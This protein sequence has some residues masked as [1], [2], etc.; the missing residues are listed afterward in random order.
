MAVKHSTGSDGTFSA[1]GATAWDA[2][3]TVDDNTLVAA[4]LSMAAANKILGSIVDEQS[5]VVVPETV[6]QAKALGYKAIRLDAARGN[7]DL[8]AKIEREIDA[9][10]ASEK[11]RIAKQDED[12][13][14]SFIQWI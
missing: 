5:Q 13:F 11:I 8:L 9:E 2:N 12:D 6:K 10:L 3:H 1:S 4:K 7:Y 14:M